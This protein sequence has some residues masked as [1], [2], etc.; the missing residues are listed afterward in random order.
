VVSIKQ[1]VDEMNRNVIDTIAVIARSALEEEGYGSSFG[2]DTEEG[3]QAFYVSDLG[4]GRILAEI[5]IKA[6]DLPGFQPE[7]SAK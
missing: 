2:H 5:V 4:S 7:T 6:P 1:E 3:H